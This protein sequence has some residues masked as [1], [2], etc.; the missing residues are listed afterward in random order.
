MGAYVGMARRPL[1]RGHPHAGRRVLSSAE[2]S[3]N[4]AGMVHRKIGASALG[5]LA[6]ISYPALGTG[7]ELECEQNACQGHLF[8]CVACHAPFKWALAQG[9]LPQADGA[10]LTR[11]SSWGAQHGGLLLQG[12]V[13]LAR[14][15][16]PGYLSS[17][18]GDAMVEPDG[19]C[20]PVAVEGAN[21]SLVTL[22]RAKE[23]QP[24]SG[25]TVEG[26]A[27]GRPH[28]SRRL[29][30]RPAAREELTNN[31]APGPPHAIDSG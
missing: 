20:A 31:S 6:P 14:A 8:P 13:G 26:S 22:F 24:R 11:R 3:F 17:S 5:V 30:T 15:D 23:K 25:R 1:P 7:Q 18:P 16:S 4:K 21:R 29:E 19:V 28:R 27:C 12:L 2:G 9:A 10:A